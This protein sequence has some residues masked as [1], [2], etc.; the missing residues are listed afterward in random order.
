MSEFGLPGLRDS[1]GHRKVVTHSFETNA[2]ESVTI[3]FRP[4][5]INALDDLEELLERDEL[6][7]DEVQEP[8]NQHLV[9]PSIP[10]DEDWTMRE[11]NAYITAIYEWSVGA[12]GPGSDIADELDAR[13]DGEGN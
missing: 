10:D 7:A 1:D 13:M 12:A 5:T 4:P 9:E 6:N 3:K 2:G 11:F 8:L